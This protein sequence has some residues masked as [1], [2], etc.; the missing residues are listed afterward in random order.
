[1]ASRSEDFE[2][3]DEGGT[4]LEDGKALRPPA[5]PDPLPSATKASGSSGGGSG[6]SNNEDDS[7]GLL[8]VWTLSKPVIPPNGR[9]LLWPGEPYLRV[10]KVEP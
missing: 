4:A 2:W 7:A 5:P 9:G 1:M 8:Y 3:D 10:A 6:S